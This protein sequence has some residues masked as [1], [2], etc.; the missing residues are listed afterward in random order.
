MGQATSAAMTESAPQIPAGGDAAITGHCHVL[1]ELS[2]LG[3][4]IESMGSET[5]QLY[6][7]EFQD[8]LNEFV[9]SGDRLVKVSTGKFCIVLRNVAQR[10]HIELAASKLERHLREPVDILDERLYFSVAMGFAIPGPGLKSKRLLQLAE[11]ALRVSRSTNQTTVILDLKEVESARRPDP[12]LLARLEDALKDGEFIPYYQP[13]IEAVYRRVEGAECLI[14]WHDTKTRKII[15]PDAFIETVEDSQLAGPLT[16]MML[17]SAVAR[18]SQWS[19][20]LSVAMNVPPSLLESQE[21][22]SGVSDVLDFYGLAPGR[23]TVEITERG[24]LPPNILEHLQALRDLGVKVSID[25]FGTGA[26]SLSYFRDLPADQVKIDRS[27]VQA[28]RTSRKDLAI[29]RGCI[30]LAR[31]CEMEV[32][33]EGVEDRKTARTLVELGCN[34]LQGYWFGRPVIG[35][36]FE[37]N[38]LQ[39]LVDDREQDR[40]TDLLNM[41]D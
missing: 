2:G 21:F 14:R 17:R 6:L 29:V 24:E 26:C 31:H 8:R 34:V 35:D 13:K 38:Y 11:S 27:F 39:G 5:C 32:V 16:D 40:F 4:I 10:H 28:M 18:C 30:D 7:N 3:A 36:E 20:P 23:L 9:R 12:A 33:A 41:D 1:V 22:V 37:Q 15:G 25:D 19:D